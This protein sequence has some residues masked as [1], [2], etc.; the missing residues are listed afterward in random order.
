MKINTNVIYVIARR[1]LLSYFSSPTGYVFITLFIFLSAAAAFWQE[2]F[3]ADN[4]A[5]LDQLNKYFSYLLLFFIPALTMSVWADEKKQGTDEL[6][7]TLPAT[8]TE[9]VLGKYF[10]LV[11]IYS[12]SLLLSLSH[13]LVLFWLGSPDIGLMFANYMGYWLLGCALLSLGMLAS[14]VTSNVTVAFVIGALLCGFFIF[15]D[16]AFIRLSDSLTSFFAPLGIDKNFHLFTKGIISIPALIFFVSIAVVM[17]YLNILIIGRRHWPMTG[18]GMKYRVHQLIRAISVVV[19]VVAFNLILNNFPMRLD[20]TAEQMHSLSDDTKQLLDQLPD[21][22]PVLVQAFISPDVPREYVEV[23]SN[24]INKLEEI[25][26]LAGDKVQVL[27]HDTEPFSEEARD[28]REKFG[29]FPQPVI[30][31]AGAQASQFDLFLGVAFTSGYN[32]EVIPFFN[33]GL[34]V[35]YELT[36]SIRVAAKSERK[37][38]GI[39]NTAVKMFGDFNYQ[40]MSQS[41][42]WSVVSELRKQYDVVQIS[43]ETP[44][45]DSL[46]ALLCVLPSSLSQPELDNLQDY[47]LDG[48]PT[49]LLIDPLPVFDIN[50]A[51]PLPPGGGQ[52]NPFSGQQPEAKPKGNIVNFIDNLGISWAG[53]HI[54]WDSYN[55]HPD[56]AEVSP[57]VIFIGEGNGSPEPFN[58]M[59]PVTSGLQELVAIYSGYIF[60]GIKKDFSFLPLLR[61]GK[62]SGLIPWNQLVGR[63]FMGMGYRLNPNPPRYPTSET[64]ILAGYVNGEDVVT[65]SSGAVVD[66]EKIKAI[67]VSDADFIS[68]QFFQLRLRG[69]KNL[70]FDNVTFFLNAIDFLAGD[71]SFIALRKKRIKH[72]TLE[73]VEAQTNQFVQQ[74]IE[75]EKAAET[76]AT[77]ALDEAQSRL[78][79]KVAEVQARTDLDSRTKQIMAQNLREVESRRF[80]VLQA[81]IMAEKEAT[82]AASKEKTEESI[83][84]IQTRIKSM[85]V[86]LPP[87]PVLIFGILIFIR[88]KKRERLGAISSRRLRS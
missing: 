54:V 77:A 76:K 84:S 87:I 37:R 86:L 67:V 71:S 13:L 64:Y 83:R 21:D 24:L 27:I 42:P 35:E 52:S 28:A 26:S 69:I 85:A 81:N 88:R 72:R 51:P 60:K 40:S 49:M 62:T 16:S 74:R 20:V 2:R 39:L 11:G 23:R 15:I 58:E 6:L 36:R 65:D 32:E 50:L 5:N 82:V 56:L 46:D 41:R 9:V 38:V 63:G 1:N 10:S 14:L 33:K 3:F 55:P 29:I 80:E 53:L 79:A 45:V 43:A 8:D 57:E 73:T 75:E 18:G 78:D 70:N 34:P 61:T 47:I 17:L 22:R 31:Q 68:E 44:I 7:L 59:N 30:S 25:S 19:A 66:T 4:L 48:H 12:I